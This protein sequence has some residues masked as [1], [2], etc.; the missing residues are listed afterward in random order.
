[1][2][3]PSFRSRL[4]EARAAVTGEYSSISRV[5]DALLDLRSLASDRE[6]LVAELDRTISTMP[7]RTVTPNEW[8]LEQL[9]HIEIQHQR[10][11]G[12]DREA[13]ATS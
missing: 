2:T 13:L 10:S 11:G 8:W 7:G 5:V 12:G 1:M 3:N 6:D 4:T 9:D